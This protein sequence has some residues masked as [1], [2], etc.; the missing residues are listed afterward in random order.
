MHMDDPAAAKVLSDEYCGEVPENCTD[1][2]INMELQYPAGSVVL[3]QTSDLLIQG[4]SGS[5]NVTVQ[6][7][8]QDEHIQ[9]AALGQYNVVL[10][11]QFGAE[12]P[13]LDNVWLL[14][15]TVGGIS[16]NWPKFCDPSRDEL[17][18]QAQATTDEATRI[19]LYQQIEQKIARR[20][21]VHL[22]R[23]H[24]VVERV[25]R[26]RPRRVRPRVA[27]GC[28]ACVASRTDATGSR[29]SG[30]PS[31]TPEESRTP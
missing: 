4:W 27:R 13:A 14:C 28:A 19:D 11:R 10:W 21:P 25:R 7:L 8:P 9:E 15:R 20:L 5:F 12:D 29:P 3:D 6:T 30:C 22:P 17:L 31:K 16:L 2:K 1:G 26:E 18:L 23:P 24:A